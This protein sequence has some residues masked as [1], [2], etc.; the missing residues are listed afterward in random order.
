MSA[1]KAGRGWVGAP[2]VTVEPEHRG[3]FG[4]EVALRGGDGLISG[5]AVEHSFVHAAG[6]RGSEKRKEGETD[7]RVS[8]C[9]EVDGAADAGDLAADGAETELVGDG[10]A[11]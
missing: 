10:G 5:A 1:R 8:V 4:A 6:V 7:E 3:A 11:A 9:A 2:G